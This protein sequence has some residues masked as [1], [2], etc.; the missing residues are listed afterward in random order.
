MR[1]PRVYLDSCAIQRPLDV[2]SQVRI[3]LEA[4]AVLGII[5]MC[6]AGQVGLISSEVL[7]DELDQNP[8][9]ARREHAWAVLAK[10]QMTVML[11][12]DTEKRAGEL[13]SRGLK[14]FDALHVASAEAAGADFLC[15][16]D[17]RLLRRLR[18]LIGIK[19]KAVSP[20][21]LIEELEQ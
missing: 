10:A 1:K 7:L 17:D 11:D 18:Q 15:T 14:P 12:E 4:E 16:C 9:P 8:W 3:S 19:V 6:D 13:I 5:A 20:L 21:E 2:Y